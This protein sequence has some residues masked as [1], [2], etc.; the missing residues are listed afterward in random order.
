MCRIVNDCEAKGCGYSLNDHVI[1]RPDLTYSLMGVLL[2]FC[3][4]D[5]AFISDVE[6]MFM[7]VKV[8]QNHRDVLR[9][10]W[11][12]DHNIDAPSATY[13][14]TSDLFGSVWS[15]IYA[16]FALQSTPE[17]FRD[18]CPDKVTKTLNRS[19]DADDC[20]KSR[21]GMEET[22]H[23]ATQLLD[24]LAK[25]GFNLTKWVPNEPDL[26]KAIPQELWGQ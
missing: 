5:M 26:L 21:N 23:L 15:P 6:A 18:E 25:S 1:Q 13:R 4:G 20:L 7:Q 22:T 14:M 8:N 10:L 16:N 2:S 24:L 17:E 11:F 3:Q 9:F 19:F 12:E